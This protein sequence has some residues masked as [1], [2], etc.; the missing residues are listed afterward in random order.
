MI[1]L[2][3]LVDVDRDLRRSHLDHATHLALVLLTSH[4]QIVMQYGGVLV[5]IND[6]LAIITLFIL[7]LRKLRFPEA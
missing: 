6:I 3:C 1:H 2:D 5:Y 4:I 7:P